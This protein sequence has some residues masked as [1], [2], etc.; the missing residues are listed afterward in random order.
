MGEDDLPQLA[1]ARVSPEPAIDP[2]LVEGEQA[3]REG[4]SYIKRDQPPVLRHP[5][6]V[7]EPDEEREQRRRQQTDYVSAEE[8]AVFFDARE[9]R[10]Y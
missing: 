5:R 7:F 6:Q 8:V 9:K 3:E 1:D 4:E 10:H 2:G